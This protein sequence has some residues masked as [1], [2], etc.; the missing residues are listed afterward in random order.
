MENLNTQLSNLEIDNVP[1]L[2]KEAFLKPLPGAE[3]QQ[4][5][6]SV[7]RLKTGW[8]EP[9]KNAKVSAVLLALSYKDGNVSL[10]FI[11][12]AIDHKVH[13]GQIAF[14]GGRKDDTDTDL[15]E[16]ALR[17]TWEEIGIEVT[18][19]QV[20]GHLTP[21]YIPPSNSLVTPVVAWLPE[22]PNRYKPNESEVDAVLEYAITDFQNEVNRKETEVKV[23]G[24]MKLKTPAFVFQE[25]VIWG[26]TA[27]IMSEFL[28]V[29]KNLE[30]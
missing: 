24:D 20:L 23:M 7:P 6:S 22:S 17:E 13:S 5:M 28:T 11:R 2:L 19:N 4:Q 9:P 21:L 15:T 1:N 8:V 26:A 3:A 25:T 29:W 12:R 27:M 16:T 18:K 14:P 30:L 10:P